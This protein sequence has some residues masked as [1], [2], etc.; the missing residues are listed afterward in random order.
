MR[1]QSNH[2]VDGSVLEHLK[3]GQNALSVVGL[4][5]GNESHVLFHV[6]GVHVVAVVREF[7]RVVRDQEKGVRKEANDVVQ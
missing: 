4:G 6:A 3:G 7:P 5:S 1:E 2:L